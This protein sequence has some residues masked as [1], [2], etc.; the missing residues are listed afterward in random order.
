MYTTSFAVDDGF[1]TGTVYNN[2]TVKLDGPVGAQWGTYFGTVTTTGAITTTSIQLRYYTTTPEMYGYA[3]TNFDTLDA[4]KIDFWAKAVAGTSIQVQIS[5]DG[6]ANWI[7]AEEFN[8]T[9]TATLYTYTIGSEH[10]GGNFRF[11]FIISTPSGRAD[12]VIDDVS[13]YGMR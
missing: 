8:L 1:T 7:G 2:Q 10:L 3:F 4:T 12:V 9:T 13:I 5:K 6:G 11:R